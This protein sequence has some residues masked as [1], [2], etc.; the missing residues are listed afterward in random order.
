MYRTIIFHSLFF[1]CVSAIAQEAKTIDLGNPPKDYMVWTSDNGLSRVW[2]GSH[3]LFT[4]DQGVVI[5]EYP[6]F[7]FVDDYKEGLA[8]VKTKFEKCGYINDEARIVI[9]PKWITCRPA[10]G[11]FAL[12][13]DRYED[14]YL[15][16]KTGETVK[17][18][19]KNAINVLGMVRGLEKG[20]KELFIDL[21]QVN[22]GYYHPLMKAIK[23]VDEIPVT[24][25]LD[26]PN[27]K[28]Y[29]KN[30]DGALE[31]ELSI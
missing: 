22:F 29:F 23:K 21:S 9:H 5:K 20:G 6:Q 18:P 7:K 25:E 12:V 4:N 3:Y 30:V 14:W 8:V 2:T 1:L 24:S 13:Q 11:G 27:G 17:F 16:K 26:E 28:I 10:S 19:L 31:Y 15:V